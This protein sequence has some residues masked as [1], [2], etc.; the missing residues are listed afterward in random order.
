MWYDLPP[1]RGPRPATAIVLD[2]QQRAELR[3]QG[4]SR[5]LL[6]QPVQRAC[7]Q[8]LIACA[9]GESG[10]ALGVKKNTVVKWHK[11]YAEHGG[12]GLH[13]E[14]RPGHGGATGVSKST[15]QRWFE[16][17]TE[18]A[19]RNYRLRSSTATRDAPAAS[20]PAGPPAHATAPKSRRHP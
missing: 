16:L 6:H 9:D 7:A 8:I 17:R 20:G 19:A 11:R 12:A 14:L 2:D 13:D 5:T 18:N 4:A 1:R 3:H 10:T 15:V